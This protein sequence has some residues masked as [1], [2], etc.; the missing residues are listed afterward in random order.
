MS[1]VSGQ[2]KSLL[3]TVHEGGRWGRD[4]FHDHQLHVVPHP[5]PWE[6][7]IQAIRLAWEDARNEISVFESFERPF[8]FENLPIPALGR[9]KMRIEAMDESGSVLPNS[10]MTIDLDVVPE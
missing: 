10:D 9:L 6:S 3:G 2:A 7:S 1:F 5:S 8:V 4:T